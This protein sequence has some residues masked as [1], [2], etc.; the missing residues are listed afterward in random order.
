MHKIANRTYIL[1]IMLL[2]G[3]CFS[4]KS[5]FQV[6][7]NTFKAKKPT[8]PHYTL[9][10]K[11]DSVYYNG[12]ANVNILGKRSV[13]ISKVELQNL[14][15]AFEKNNFLSLNETYQGNKRDIP[16]TSIFYKNHTVTFQKEYA[17]EQLKEINNVLENLV[18]NLER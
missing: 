5:G 14:K 3:S 8:A 9:E 12:I 16:V 1:F 15:E 11:K 4:V 13:K 17:P 7:Y 6:K 10:I 2:F 18:K